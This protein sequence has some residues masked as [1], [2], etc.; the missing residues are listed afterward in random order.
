MNNAQSRT[1]RKS[2][3]EVSDRPFSELRC[4]SIYRHFTGTVKP[5]QN[6][7]ETT[8]LEFP[9]TGD[10]SYFRQEPH[11]TDHVMRVVDF[12]ELRG[13]HILS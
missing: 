1:V 2:C 5:P 9:I 3:T 10:E 12:R 4:P 13:P 7:P 11:T 6:L 8:I